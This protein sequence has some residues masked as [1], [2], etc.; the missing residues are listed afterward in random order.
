MKENVFKILNLLGVSHTL[1]YFKNDT[2]TILN[3]HRITE[4]RDEF[5]N[6][7]LPSTFYQIIDY[8]C[9]YYSIVSFEDIEKKT[10]RPKLILSFDDGY[11]DFIEYALPY[12][13]KKGLP[14]N[15]NVVNDCL[16]NNTPI[17]THRLNSIFHFLKENNITND[18]VIA[19]FTSFEKNWLNYYQK[20]FIYLLSID[21]IKRESVINKIEKEYS[22]I[23]TSKMMNWDDLKTC[24]KNDVEIGSHTYN[25]NSLSSIYLKDSLIV[26]VSNSIK[27]IETKLNYN[28]NI[29][30]LPNGQ[31]NE[32]SLDFIKNSG[33]KFL[34]LVDDLVNKNQ[35]FSSFNKM[36]R[37]GLNDCGINETILKIELFHTIFRKYAR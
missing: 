32:T 4:E 10:L 30:A 17:W 16:N 36:S 6:P 8:C 24:I 18:H 22:I 2:I 9:R 1:R 31:Y 19:E 34:L 27:E 15:H 11:Y 14:S 25:H 7:I 20:F 13:V 29:L 3:L 12:L 35:K 26:E 28:V 37:I 33:V 23:S 21:N 5:Y